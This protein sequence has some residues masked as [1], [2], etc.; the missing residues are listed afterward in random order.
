MDS[1][2]LREIVDI[3]K[4]GGI[5][6]LRLETEEFTL[7]LE[8]EGMQKQE[9]RTVVQESKVSTP[10]SQEAALT[11]ETTSVAKKSG[12]QILSPMVGT[13]YKAPSPSSPSFANVG[14]NIKKDQPVAIIEAMKIM[15][16]IN[17][18]FNCKI[19]EILVE[20]GQPVEFNTPLFLVERL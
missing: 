13:F 8:K 6:K 17:A 4:D 1:Q 9:V 7:L 19:L 15:N 12:E 3:F 20:D 16:E 18:E 10:I 14:D 5:G 11:Q 2:K